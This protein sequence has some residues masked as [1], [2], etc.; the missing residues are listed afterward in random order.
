MYHRNYLMR[1]RL[2]GAWRVHSMLRL[3]YAYWVKCIYLHKWRSLLRAPRAGEIE[4][5]AEIEEVA[6]EWQLV[7]E[8]AAQ[9]QLIEDATY[10]FPA[11]EGA[12]VVIDW[13]DTDDG[14]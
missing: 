11:E 2:P 10:E 8:G 12:A 6:A 9:W 3:P 13:P 14:F 7:E 4:E 5:A 1:Q